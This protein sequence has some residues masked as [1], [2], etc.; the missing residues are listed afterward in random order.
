M[1]DVNGEQIKP[2]LYMARWKNSLEF[3]RYIV[4]DIGVV[5]DLIDRTRVSA[6]YD[7]GGN[8]RVYLRDSQNKAGCYRYVD[9]LVSTLH[10]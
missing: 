2:H 7:P 9:L 4:S 10:G 6:S 5:Y 1:T 8:K 3:P